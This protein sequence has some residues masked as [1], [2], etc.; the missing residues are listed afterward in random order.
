MEF[1]SSRMNRQDGGSVVGDNKIIGPE[2]SSN[3]VADIHVDVEMVVLDSSL[4]S[5]DPRSLRFFDFFFFRVEED[6]EEDDEDVPAT[7]LN[8][9]L[10]FMALYGDD[11]MGGRIY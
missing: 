6:E 11:D 5:S 4:S 3:E 8:D 9:S 10:L 2:K 1:N 7:P